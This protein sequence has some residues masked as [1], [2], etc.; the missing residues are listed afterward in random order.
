MAVENID[1]TRTMTKSPQ[2]NSIVDAFAKNHRL[3][4]RK[5]VYAS[6]DALQAE[7]FQVPVS[8]GNLE[9]HAIQRKGAVAAALA[10]M[11]TDT[12]GPAQGCRLGAGPRDVGAG[13]VAL[14]GRAA[15]LGVLL[16]AAFLLDPGLRGEIQLL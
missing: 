2:T 1:H 14:Q 10:A 16:P 7:L 8:A 13:Q 3:V 15:Q 4:C 11:L 9:A 12:E 5:K 6:I